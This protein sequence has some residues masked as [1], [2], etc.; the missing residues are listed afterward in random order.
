MAV[1]R[2]TYFVVVGEILNESDALTSSL[3]AVC[4][5]FTCEEC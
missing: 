1:E 5:T 4:G 2:T 3:A